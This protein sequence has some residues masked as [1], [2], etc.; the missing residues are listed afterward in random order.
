MSKL[1]Q[2]AAQEIQANLAQS[3]NEIDL[4]IASSAKL[5]AS[6][7]SARVET[8]SPFGTGMVAIMRLAK[9]IDALAGARADMARVHA[10]LLRVGQERADYATIDECPKGAAVE[11]AGLKLVA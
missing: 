11:A 6:M 9:S 2:S 4:A 5:L 3:E 1:V 10:D 7:V 8:S